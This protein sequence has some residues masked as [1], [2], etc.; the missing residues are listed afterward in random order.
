MNH[1]EFSALPVLANGTHRDIYMHGFEIA[2]LL[3]C[4]HVRAAFL[5]ATDKR[6]ACPTRFDVH[7]R[8]PIRD[9]VTTVT[10]AHADGSN[11]VQVGNPWITPSNP[12]KAPPYPRPMPAR[13]LRPSEIGRIVWFFFAAGVSCLFFEGKGSHRSQIPAFGAKITCCTFVRCGS[14]SRGINVINPRCLPWFCE[15]DG[16]QE[17]QQFPPT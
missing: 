3:A 16:R 13:R 1:R 7:I 9:C 11:E 14:R 2:R 5:G 17:R 4:C 10:Q 15:A 12:P 6:R 8:D